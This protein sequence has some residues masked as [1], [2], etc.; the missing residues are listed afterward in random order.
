MKGIKIPFLLDFLI[1]SK[2]ALQM[3]PLNRGLNP[4]SDL[5]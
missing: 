5:G 2:K 3:C 1:E 4:Y